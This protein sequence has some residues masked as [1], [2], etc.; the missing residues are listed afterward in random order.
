MINIIPTPK[1]I[2]AAE[3][4]FNL[5]NAYITVPDNADRRVV[6]AAA[7][8]S[9]EMTKAAKTLVPLTAKEKSNGCISVSHKNGVGEG[10]FLKISENMIEIMSES[11]AGAFYAIQ[12][13]RQLVLENGE[14]LPCCTVEDEPDFPVRGFY[15][16]ITRGRV[17]TLKKLKDIVDLLSYYKVNSLQ[18]YVEDAFLFKE[19]EGILTEDEAMTAEE[20]T[21]LDSYCRE[22]F[23][24]LVPSLSTFGHLFTLLQ[25]EKY[26]YLSEFPDHKMTANYWMEKQW[27]H[28]VNVYHPDTEKVIGSMIEQYIPLFSSDKFNIC[29]DETMDLC[30]G[31]NAGCDKE[32]AYFRHVMK[33]VNIVK[34]HGKTVLLWG[35]ECMAHPEKSKELLPEDT[36]VL[37]WCY[38]KTVPEWI[39][40]FFSDLGIKQ[41]VCP[42]TSSWSHFIEDTNESIGNITDFAAYGK[43]YGAL[44]LLNTNWGD[45]GHICSF[46]CNLYGTLF[47]AQKSWNV[48][49]KTDGEFTKSASFLLYGVTEFDMTE[50]VAALC[51][52]EKSCDWFRYVMWHSATHLEGREAEL[53]YNKEA[54]L[55]EKDA[56]EGIATCEKEI[57]KLRSLDRTGDARIDDVILSAEAIALM[58]RLYLLKNS[59]PGYTDAK[60]L[61]KDFNSWLER[62]KK[63]WLRDDKP[64]Q[65]PRLAEFIEH[66]TE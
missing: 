25:S 30:R 64:S 48:D 14:N 54:G 49:S 44:G 6:S 23:I 63:A 43:K 55:T 52:A 17:N 41:I 29:C 3:G 18:L 24:E 11:A 15:Q 34:S 9:R 28:T 2:T 47:G 62:Y 26:H 32:E 45:F 59:V 31:V 39:P 51:K 13:L 16:D 12:S 20:M 27:H 4:T 10:Y 36:V 46:N 19:F 42:G 21:A 33:L 58:E 65:L 53:H 50:T 1:K 56:I 22:H 37:N 57:E 38:H 60:E 35:D 7:K 40:K 5:Q 61:Q 8:L 66:I